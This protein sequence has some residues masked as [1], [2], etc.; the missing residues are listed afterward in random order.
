MGDHAAE[1]GNV[2]CVPGRPERR[3]LTDWTAASAGCPGR[4]SGGANLHAVHGH[5]GGAQDAAPGLAGQVGGVGGADRD[6]ERQRQVFV[7]HGPVHVRV[8]RGEFLGKC[9]ARHRDDGTELIS[10]PAGPPCR[11]GQCTTGAAA[12]RG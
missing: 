8:Q 4:E 6:G 10:P 5:V 3:P 1:A 12:D 7:G 9:L 11:A 2:R